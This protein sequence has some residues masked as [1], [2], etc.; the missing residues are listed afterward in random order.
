MGGSGSGGGGGSGRVSYPTYMETIHSDWLDQTG[1]DTIEASITEVMNA[2]IGASPFVTAAA[3]DPTT[4]LA[5]AWTAVCAFNTLA[6]SLDNEADWLSAVAAARTEYDTNV[7]DTT[8][9]DDDVNAFAQVLE[10]NLDYIQ[11]PKIKA[12]YRTA[13]AVMTSAFPIAEAVLRGMGM[14]DIAKYATELR[15]K[16]HFLRS[17]WILKA[18]DTMLANLMQRVSFEEAVARISVE[19][20]RIHIVAS[21]EQTDQDYAFDEA[22]AKWDMETF[23]YGAN[24]LAAIGGGTVAPGK[25]RPSKVSSALGGALSGAAAGAM[26]FPAN[27]LLGAGIGAAF[28]IGASLF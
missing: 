13:N 12:G 27:P 9:I 14:R 21:K 28:G 18:A 3:Y 25:E 11:V 1:T 16:N 2:A 20:K 4:P 24:V 23:Q 7:V 15:V 5:D 26:A 19:A 17:E 6:D 22:D 10:D 8:Q